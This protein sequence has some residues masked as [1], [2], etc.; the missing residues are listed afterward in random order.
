[1][2]RFAAYEAA[3]VPGREREAYDRLLVLH[4]EG[5]RMRA[6]NLLTLLR[7]LE[8]Q[9]KIPAAQRIKEPAPASASPSHPANPSPSPR[10]RS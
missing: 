1:L 8:E 9:L 3:K 10:P 4:N 2:K 7:K 5:G 6:P